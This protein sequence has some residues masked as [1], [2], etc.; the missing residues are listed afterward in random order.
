MGPRA[1]RSGR[2]SRRFDRFGPKRIFSSWRFELFSDKL[3]LVKRRSFWGWGF[4]GEGPDPSQLS[5][6]E[7]GLSALLG[8]RSVERIAPPKIESI[9]LPPPRIRA[10]SSLERLLSAD[11]YDRAGHSYGKS[12]RDIVRGLRGDFARPPDYVAFPTSE[13]EIISILDW[14]ASA[15]IAA[16]PY[17]G[18]SSVCGGV[19]ADVGANFAGVI[20]LDLGRLD[21]V[22]E[23]DEASLSARI[24]AGALGPGLEAQLKEYGLSLRHYPQSFEHSTLGGWIATRSGGHFATLRTQI[25]DFVQSLRVITPSGIVETR[26]LPASGAGPSPDRLFIGSEGILG[27]I[28]EAWMRVQRRPVFR[29]SATIGFKDF[30]AGAKA[31]KLLAQSGLYPSNCRLLDPLEA[32][33]NGAGAGD[34]AILL[35]G[36]ES[37]DHP[38]EAWMRRALEIC[39]GA[40]GEISEGSVRFSDGRGEAQEREARAEA[41]RSAFMKAPYLRDALVTM[42]MVT[43]TFET[44]ITWDR[45]EDFYTRVKEATRDAVREVCGAGLVTC[46]LTHLYPDG[47]APYFTVVAP[48]KRGSEISQWDAIKAAATET[49]LAQG[50]TVTH[51]HAVGRDFRAFYEKERPEGFARALQAVKNELDPAGIL[52]PGVLVTARS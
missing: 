3:A 8:M 30:L 34:R 20:S 49:I 46:R 26:R 11:A 14:C 21:Q 15:H 23:V 12:Y 24:Q 48:A 7:S 10:P 27:V 16:I 37:A 36:F 9:R 33:I 38:L 17:G 1:I 41:W 28:S 42:G 39:R 5:A 43:E 44:A 45:F 13:A 4:E 50:G 2:S 25:D 6:V 19:E 22:I 52:N 31:A 32:M 47:A 18:G 40:G 51:H 29:A 35:L